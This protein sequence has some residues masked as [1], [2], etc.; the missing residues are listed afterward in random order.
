MPRPLLLASTSA[1]RLQ[2]LS[3]AGLVATAAPARID[4]D[5]IRQALE[6]E[7]AKPHEIADALAEMKARK[8]ADKN[9]DRLVLGCDQ[10]LEFQSKVWSKAETVAEARVQLQ[11]LR[12]Q[13][14]RLHSALV[15][16]DDAK[17]IWRHVSQ[18][19]LTMTNFSDH[20]LDGYLLRNWDAAR[21]SVGVYMLEAE[22]VRL[23]SSV[24]GDHFTILGL[25][26]LPLITY[27]GTRGFI[28]T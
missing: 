28:D 2:I 15:L 26:L 11:N 9:P 4:E 16:Y 27:L 24:Q 18:A 25:P 19:T 5:A 22:G 14:H 21:H 12:G 1:I 13:T 10:I 20:Y 17:P 7:A 8:I 23:F 3:N 6:A